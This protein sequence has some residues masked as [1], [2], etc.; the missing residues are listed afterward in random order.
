MSIQFEKFVTVSHCVKEFDKVLVLNDN[1]SGVV[2]GMETE[3]FRFFQIF[4][5]KHMH[6]MLGVV[7]Q[8]EGGDTAGFQSKIF[9]HPCFRR[10]AELP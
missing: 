1:S 9:V 6:M 3:P 10:E 7:D 8:S 5:N 4:V 2:V